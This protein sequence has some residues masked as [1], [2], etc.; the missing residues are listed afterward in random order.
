MSMTRQDNMAARRHFSGLRKC[1]AM[2]GFFATRIPMPTPDEKALLASDIR[3]DHRCTCPERSKSGYTSQ[4]WFA[5]EIA[6]ATEAPVQ[7]IREA[8]HALLIPSND[9]RQCTRDFPPTVTLLGYVSACPSS[10]NAGMGTENYREHTSSSSLSRFCA[11]RCLVTC[12]L[13]SGLS[14]QR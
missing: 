7:R 5:E 14:G 10:T 3:Q 13:P 1:V 9:H 11:S 2:K 4:S 8:I 6:I 12:S